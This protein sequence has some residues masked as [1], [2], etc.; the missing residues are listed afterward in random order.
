MTRKTEIAR[1]REHVDSLKPLEAVN[2]L[3]GCL[4]NPADCIGN[5]HH[6][7]DDVLPNLKPSHRKMLI[8][9]WNAKG[10]VVSK[11]ALIAGYCFGRRK[12]DPTDQMVNVTIYNLRKVIPESIGRIENVWGRGYRWVGADA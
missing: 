7:V 5:D 1:I 11:E 9:L 2:Y 10:D 12:D 3:L 8:I 6:P 4:E